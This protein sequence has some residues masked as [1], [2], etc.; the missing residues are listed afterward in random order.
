[1]D[2]ADAEAAVDAGAEFI[3]TPVML[4]DVIQWCAGRNIVIAPGRQTPTKMV[5]A[6]R[7]GAPLQKLFLFFA[8][9]DGVE[10]KRPTEHTWMRYWG[11]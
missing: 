4:P 5:N 9:V 2:V 10:W 3:I 8:G 11:T 7:H 1:M 6:Y